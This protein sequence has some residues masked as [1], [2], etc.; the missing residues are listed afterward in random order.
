V[1]DMMSLMRGKV[2]AGRMYAWIF[3]SYK[4]SRILCTAARLL[5]ALGRVSYSVLGVV[6][7]FITAAM[8][9]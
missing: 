9:I 1:V 5:L 2:L 3:A 4:C 7:D 6:K 8:G